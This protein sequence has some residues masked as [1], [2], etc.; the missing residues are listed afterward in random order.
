M[1]RFVTHLQ[2]HNLIT[3][4]MPPKVFILVNAK[5]GQ[6]ANIL[7]T[8]CFRL[9]SKIFHAYGINILIDTL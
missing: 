7:L 8:S 4:Y 9:P 1:S 3:D 6:A 2:N 5:I